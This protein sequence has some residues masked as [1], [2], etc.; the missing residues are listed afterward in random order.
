MNIPD[1]L[2]RLLPT[3]ASIPAW[4]QT[5]QTPTEQK[6]SRTG[7]LIA[8]DGT[9]GPVW[10]TRDYAAF[11]R[12]GFMQ[13]AVVYRCVRMIAEAA[14]SIPLCLYDGPH[15]LEDH[16]LLSLLASPSPHQTGTDFL[17]SFIGYL[18]VS[19]NSYVEAVSLN[20]ELRELYALRPDRM[21]VLPGLSGWPEGYE[22]TA[23]GGTARFTQDV[24][25][26][27]RPILHMRLFH[28]LDDHYGMSPIE[29]AATAIDIHNQASKW[30][31]ALLDNA[32]RPSGA[33][34]Y[35]A[36]EGRLSP[37]SNAK[38]SGPAWKNQRSTDDEKRAAAGYGVI[39]AT[40]AAK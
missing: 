23:A 9:S 19:G 2:A 14:A 16:P 37:C 21:T 27:V 17:E 13:N 28:P 24:V 32:A 38:P 39:I 10:S 8:F 40:G 1:A 22:Y 29:A 36:R 15:E 7:P 11:S 30:N 18:L 25:P 31:K 33:L 5:R 34:V 26:G 4:A 20:G 6:A 12:E 35:A 3:R